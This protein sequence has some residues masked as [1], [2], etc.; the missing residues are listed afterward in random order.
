MP[1]LKVWGNG[2]RCAVDGT[3]E[4]I[5]NNNMIAEHHIRYGKKGGVGFRHV[6]D[7][8]IAFFSQF[9]RS[10]SWEAIY[11]IDGL[12]RNSSEVNPKIVHGDTQSQSLPVFAFSYLFGIKLMPRIRN[13]KGLNIY[14][15]D[16]IPN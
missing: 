3:F 9:I 15:A 8:Y 16:I 10:G 2:E 11:I 5:K 7:N 12:L 4:D 6:S 14:K 1:L 13:W